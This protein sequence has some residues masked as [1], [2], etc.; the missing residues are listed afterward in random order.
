MTRPLIHQVADRV[1]HQDVSM[2]GAE[3]NHLLTTLLRGKGSVQHARMLAQADRTTPTS[4]TEILKTAS[5]ISDLSE[6]T[7]W[8][9]LA[10]AFVASLAQVSAFDAML[11]A[12]TR[13]PPKT[14]IFAATTA[15]AA[16]ETSEGRQKGVSKLDLGADGLTMRKATGTLVISIEQLGARGVMGFVG[17]EL[18]RALARAVDGIFLAAITPAGSPDPTITSTNA[19]ADIKAALNAMS[20]G[21]TS[22]LYIIAAPDVAVALAMATGTDTTLLFPQ[23]TVTGGEIS[24]I[25]VMVSDALAAGTFM[26]IDAA[27]IVV[28]DEG[29]NLAEAREASVALDDE[30]GDGTALISLWQHNLVAI[31]AERWFGFHVTRDTAVAVVTGVSY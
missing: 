4:V 8:S 9:S 22:R 10:G 31:R 16:S 7:G 30:P 27:A 2:K 5:G 25:P 14:R 28:T 11:P 1:R 13:V 24:G 6:A 26:L 12:M 18:R 15:A 21:A 20:I 19:I 23:A 29:V 3:F 17:Q